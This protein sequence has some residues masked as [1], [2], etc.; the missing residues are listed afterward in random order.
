MN[1][2][3]PTGSIK[4]AL[5]WIGV[6]LFRLLPFRPPNVEPILATVMPFSKR[7]GIISSFLF[8]FLGIVIYDAATAGWGVWTWIPAVSYGLLGVASHFYFKNRAASRMNF[9]GFGIVGTLL[10]DGAT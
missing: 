2:R 9:I 1:V 6:L 4:F 3:I 5:A 8:G 7:Y 10:Y